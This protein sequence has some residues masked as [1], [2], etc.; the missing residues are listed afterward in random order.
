[1]HAPRLLA[2]FAGDARPSVAAL[3]RGV[4][5]S[6]FGARGFDR[7]DAVHP[8]FGRLFDDPFEAVELDQADA[9]GDRNRKRDGGDGF[10]YLKHHSFAAGLGDFGKVGLL[11]IGDFEALARLHAQDA[12]QVAGFVATQ[13]RGPAANGIHKEST[14]CQI[15]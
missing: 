2:A 13:F 14:P 9:E 3:A 10:D 8:Q 6:L 4:E 7:K 5:E 11:V 1:M 15:S 12:G